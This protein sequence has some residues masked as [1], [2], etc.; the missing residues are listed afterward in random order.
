MIEVHQFPCLNDNYGFLIHDN[1]SG[2]TVAIDTPDAEKYLTEADSREWKISSIWN[3]HWHPD[4]TGGNIKIVEA[5]NCTVIGP[6]NEAAKIPRIQ[7]EVKG[8]DTVS[9]GS[10]QAKIFDVPGH[11]LGHIAYHLASENK[12]FVGDALF[13]LGCGRVFEGTPSMMWN[14]LLSLRE[15]PSHTAVYCAHEYTQAN[16]KFAVTIDPDNKALQSYAEEIESKR[17][18]G[19]WTVPTS[20]EKELSTNP[21]LRCDDAELQARIGTNGDAIATFA[22]IRARKDSF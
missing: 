20:L 10:V 2:E 4:H 12:A 19:E 9:I 7:S 11:T 16:A 5:T 13:A 17:S 21:F 6:A 1:E 14:S 8:G 3:T 15:L 22:E 18:R